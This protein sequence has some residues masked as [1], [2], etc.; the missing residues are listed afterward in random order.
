M[1]WLTQGVGVDE[2]GNLWGPLDPFPQTGLIIEAPNCGPASRI[3]YLGDEVDTN[4]APSSSLLNTTL[5]LNSTEPAQ[6]KRANVNI[7]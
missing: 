5:P 2:N 4:W 6:R 7:R 3:Q 1:S